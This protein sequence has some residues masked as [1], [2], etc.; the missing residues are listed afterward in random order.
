MKPSTIVL[1]DGGGVPA[2]R[3]DL[4]LHEGEQR[5][6]GEQFVELG[7]GS[8]RRRRSRSRS[9][10]RPST[11]AATCRCAGAPATRAFSVALS[12]VARS[13]AR[14]GGRRTSISTWKSMAQVSLGGRL[15]VVRGARVA[16]EEGQPVLVELDAEPGPAGDGEREVAVLEGLASRIS[17]VSR[18]GPN[19][20][21]PQARR[22]KVAHQVRRGGGAH[23]PLE[24]GAA[25]QADPRRV[26]D[27]R[28]LR[29]GAQAARRRDLHREHVGRGVRARDR[30]RPPVRA[31]TSSAIIGTVKR[32]ARRAS[33]ARL[34][35][36][37][38]CSTRATPAASSAA[39]PHL[40]V[41]SS[42]AWFTST[43]TLA[44]SPSAR[45]I[46]AT[47]ATSSAGVRAPIFSLKSR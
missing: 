9:D 36:A 26:G 16:A 4:D 39:M 2:E 42:H 43:R 35:R 40:A 37:T 11:G 25:V 27:R 19:S 29:R 41:L 31:A 8:P 13:G 20:S 46:A 14:S 32:A 30:R 24:H 18:S 21:V 12:C 10:R 5:Q 3:R 38:G 45:L 28:H 7:W 47:C 6:R 22:G 33:A 44:R 15:W 17:S 23:R 34:A 1:A